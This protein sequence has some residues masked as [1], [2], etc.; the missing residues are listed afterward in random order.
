MA[1]IVKRVEI[2]EEVVPAFGRKPVLIKA[3]V[4]RGLDAVEREVKAAREKAAKMIADAEAEVAHIRA[5]AESKGE[6]EGAAKFLAALAVMEEEHAQWKAK[7]EP[8][9]VELALRI[10]HRIIGETALADR[11]VMRSIAKNAVSAARG[12]GNLVV[13]VHPDVAHMLESDVD[14]LARELGV[15]VSIA[16]DDGLELTDCVVQTLAGD[17]DARL[18][19]QLEAIRRVLQGAP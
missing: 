18:T 8:E 3:E 19:S 14:E 17:I 6:S 10:A 13:R 12:R 4:W 7:I 11:E 5:N 16:M 9:A 2:M 15:H 1:R